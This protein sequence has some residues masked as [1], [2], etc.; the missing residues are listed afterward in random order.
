MADVVTTYTLST[1]GGNITMN[2]GTLGDGTDKYWISAVGGLDGPEIR[3]P[4]DPVPFGDGG[5]VHTFWKGP[6]RPTFEGALLIESSTNQSDCQE[7]RN[8]MAEDLMD[9]LDSIIAADGTLSWTLTGTGYSSRQLTVRNEV[10][11]QITYESDYALATFSFG[12]IS[13][14][15]SW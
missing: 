14:S 6:R 1:P 8:T 2:S 9:A 12:L 13:A 7:I 11:L 10:P 4:V 3:A 15:A 5:I